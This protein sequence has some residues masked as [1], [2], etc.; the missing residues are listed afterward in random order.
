MIVNVAERLLTKGAALC[1]RR[2]RLGL[3]IIHC[4][5]CTT[6]D[7]LVTITGSGP[8][9][10]WHNDL[11]K[12]NSV[13]CKLIKI[14]LFTT[15]LDPDSIKNLHPPLASITSTYQKIDSCY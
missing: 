7:L 11:Q 13:I 15:S 8:E 10:K 5:V 2:C 14:Y 9:G 3:N 12:Q 1:D 6:I 4:F